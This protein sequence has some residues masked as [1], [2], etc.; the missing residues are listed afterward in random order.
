MKR[1]SL[2]PLLLTCILIA[3]GIFL[4]LQTESRI[5]KKSSSEPEITATESPVPSAT[6]I[7]T[8][9]PS[10]EP[11]PAPTEASLPTSAGASPT[12]EP[13]IT[14]SPTPGLKT[15]TSGSFRSDTGGWLNLI[16]RWN[17]LPD[18]ERTKLRLEAY[19]ESYT[20]ET[21]K[22][23]D[24]VAFSVNGTVKYDS[25][26]PLNVDSPAILVENKLG[27]AVFDVEKGSDASVKVVWNFKGSYGKREVE[28]VIAE[29]VIRIP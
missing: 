21:F 20:I 13:V 9:T 24:D 2:L 15:E 10:P 3:G 6:P 11:T 7:P 16:V 22:R 4:I 27:S 18:G 12:A 8:A 23:V 5:T 25:S 19:A 29:Q 14:P 28:D 1:S 26:G 17:I